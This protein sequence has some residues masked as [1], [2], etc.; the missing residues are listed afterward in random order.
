MRKSCG[1]E[2]KGASCLNLPI[3][4]SDPF[5]TFQYTGTLSSCLLGVTPNTKYTYFSG[6]VLP[7]G[8]AF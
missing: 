1:T 6:A 3:S 4:K 8:S 2:S 5:R 7:E